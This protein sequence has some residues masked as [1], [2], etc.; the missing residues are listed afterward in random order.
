MMN[1]ALVKEIKETKSIEEVNEL[2]KN[3]SWVL[4]NIIPN[5]QATFVL[6]RI[7]TTCN[8]RF[9]HKKAAEELQLQEQSEKVCINTLRKANGLEP[10]A[11]DIANA[12]LIKE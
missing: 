1:L 12:T 8:D 6:G 2:L 10:I 7:E 11:N 9:H 4:L 5:Q 3:E